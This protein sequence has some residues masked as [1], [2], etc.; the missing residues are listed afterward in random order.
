MKILHTSDW[1]LGKTLEKFSRIYEQ[2]LFIDELEFIC[3]NHNVDLIVISGDIYDTINPPTVAEKLFFN[4]MKRLSLN[5][6]RPIL[7]ISGNHDSPN[8]I[9]APSP[10]AYEFGIIIQAD[11]NTIAPISKFEHY[12]ILNSGKG[13]IE[14]E[15]NGERA[16]F[17]TLPYITEKSLNEIIFNSSNEYDEQQNFSNKVKDIFSSLAENF[18]DDTINVI[19]THLFVSGSIESSE[20][21]KIQS[22][23]GIYSI[24]SSVFPK[25]TQYVALGHLHR[26]QKVNSHCL[27]YYSGSPIKYSKSEINHDKYV[28][29]L[30]IFPKTTPKLQKIK[31]TDYKPIQHFKCKDF[32]QAVFLC[33]KNKSKN[34]YV[35]IDIDCTAPLSYSQIKTLKEIKSDIISIT[36]NI[37]GDLIQA[38]QPSDDINILE[39]FK[40]FYIEKNNFEPSFDILNLFQ[41]LL[42]DIEGQ[43]DDFYE[44]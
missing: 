41:E 7:I 34:S 23:G 6:K 20:E 36:P 42:S 39:Q 33:E 27:A 40:Q 35:F 43:V 22:I 26:M 18:K 3:N 12:S 8:K 37:K 24:N 15:L 29:L 25:K 21:K 38:E 28:L 44:T 11:F 30:D 5:G 17:L 32:E 1:H 14:I 31:L 16:V 2:S 10:L 9:I 13:F 19:A 4:S